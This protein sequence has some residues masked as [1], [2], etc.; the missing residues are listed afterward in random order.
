MRDWSQSERGSI[1]VV[2]WVQS[3]QGAL[4]AA[5]DCNAKIVIQG[6]EHVFEHLRG[7]LNI[8]QE[9]DAWKICFMHASFP[10]TRSALG[11]SFPMQ[12]TE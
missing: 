9:G 2:T 12:E 4:W 5:A 1:E 7:S 10:D 6:K 11:E 8:T 3:S